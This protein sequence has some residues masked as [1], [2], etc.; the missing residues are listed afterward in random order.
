M[1]ETNTFLKEK[2][3]FLLE[4]FPFI[5]SGLYGIKIGCG[6]WIYGI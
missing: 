1:D 2:Q 5:I 6:H 3:K 4:F